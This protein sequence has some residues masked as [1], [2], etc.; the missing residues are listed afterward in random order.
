ML[1]WIH[2][3]LHRAPMPYSNSVEIESHISIKSHKDQDY[4]NH[5][6]S[7]TGIS[8]SRFNPCPHIWPLPGKTTN[9]ISLPLLGSSS[10]IPPCNNAIAPKSVQHLFVLPTWFIVCS[11]SS[12]ARGQRRSRGSQYIW[13][14]KM[15]QCS[16]L[17]DARAIRHTSRGNVFP[18]N[19]V[20]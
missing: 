9:D 18:H 20:Q 3:F 10:P 15:V 7:Y 1:K 8:C 6:Q 4:Y 12:C 16:V 13:C 17:A 5:C 2:S 14:G 19:F 11:I